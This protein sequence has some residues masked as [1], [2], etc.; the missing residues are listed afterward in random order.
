LIT[1]AAAL[2]VVLVFITAYGGWRDLGLFGP[3]TEPAS[4][5]PH[6]S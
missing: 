5:S 4:A 6:P 2:L 3:H 1:I